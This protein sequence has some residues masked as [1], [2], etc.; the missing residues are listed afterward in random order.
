M[1]N[2]SGIIH[3]VAGTG[4]PGFTGDG[5]PADTA[6]IDYPYGLALND[7]NYLFVADS[8]NQR[9]RRLV[10]TDSVLSVQSL[11]AQA[12][13]LYVYPNPNKGTVQI[14][15]PAAT[16]Q[17]VAVNI[18]NVTGISVFSGEVMTNKLSSLQL[19]VPDGIYL[20]HAFSPDMKY[21]VK[22]TVLR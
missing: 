17:I 14:M 9:I 1:V 7:S 22:I 20:L 13:N 10:P 3:T 18:T 2:T 15:V 8:K 11:P 21:T 5:G 16:Q 4:V 12:A 19:D 6:E